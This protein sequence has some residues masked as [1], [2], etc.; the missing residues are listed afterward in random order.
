[1]IGFNKNRLITFGCSYTKYITATW[2]DY[3]A[4]NFNEYYNFGEGG[5]SNTF[6]MNR[7]IEADSI[8]NF[9]ENDTIII[10]FT[11]IDRFSFRNDKCWNHGGNVYFN[12][13]IPNTFLE[14]MWSEEWG[15][16]QSYIAFKTIKNIL[17]L[18]N[19]KHKIL[20][21]MDNLLI[22]QHITNPNS[23]KHLEYMYSQLDVKEVMD[24]WRRENFPNENDYIKYGDKNEYD[25]H[26][27][28]HMHYEYLKQIFPEFDTD[29]S[30]E[31]YE[32]SLNAVDT[33]TFEN[34][35]KIYA[36]NMLIPFN[37]A[38]FENPIL[39]N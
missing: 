24:I 35:F 31:R 18:K 3:A 30:K 26:P 20:N 38:F 13:D 17:T 5:A 7:F 2:A 36:K 19:V 25:T 10:M 39:F 37:K 15:I 29:A 21:A 33:S 4:A 6:I 11:N 14:K 1:M 9:N 22:Y 23:I 34:Q 32:L 27:T 16:Y 12:P 8:L 28:Q